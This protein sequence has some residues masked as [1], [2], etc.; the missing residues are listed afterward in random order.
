MLRTYTGL[1]LPTP[2]H[3]STDGQRWTIEGPITITYEPAP[4]EP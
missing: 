1:R 4:E 2:I 3:E